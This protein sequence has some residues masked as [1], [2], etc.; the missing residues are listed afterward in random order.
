MIERVT[1]VRLCEAEHK[2]ETKPRLGPPL[3]WRG[4]LVPP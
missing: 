4:L 2:E 3:H 1:D